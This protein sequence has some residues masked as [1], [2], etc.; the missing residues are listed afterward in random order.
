M[1]SSRRRHV[2]QPPPINLDTLITKK[3]YINFDVLK[4]IV[5]RKRKNYTTSL[6]KIFKQYENK[7][8]NNAKLKYI[9]KEKHKVK[10][11][12]IYDQFMQ[13]FLLPSSINFIP[14]Q[15]TKYSRR[16]NSL[17]NIL[18]KNFL[19]RYFDHNIQEKL[20]NNQLYQIPDEKHKGAHILIMAKIARAY[21][22]LQKHLK[23]ELLELQKQQQRK[24]RFADPLPT[25][26]R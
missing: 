13:E 9:R 7:K 23:K 5:N 4:G 25:L 24:E 6:G 10:S 14:K 8:T 11:I 2:R 21:D 26:K 22:T 1:S 17:K 20:R 3:N 18:E 19:L 16:L 12:P 15:H